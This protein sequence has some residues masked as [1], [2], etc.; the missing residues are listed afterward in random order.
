M[1]RSDGQTTL[2]VTLSEDLLA[3]LNVARGGLSKSAYVRAALV[4]KLNLSS[5]M[6]QAPD[7]EGKGGKPS[8]RVPAPMKLVAEE[9]V[10]YSKSARQ[11]IIIADADEDAPKES[12]KDLKNS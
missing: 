9:G 12:G 10:S 11:V 2:T 1:A 4:E 8:H 5:S 6:A 7:R 3:A